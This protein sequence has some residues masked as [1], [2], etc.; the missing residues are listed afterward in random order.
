MLPVIKAKCFQTR[1]DEG[2]YLVLG[3][4][5][6]SLNL[7]IKREIH[8]KILSLQWF[9]FYINQQLLHNA[10]QA[11]QALNAKSQFPNL[12]RLLFQC[13]PHFEGRKLQRLQLH[14][15]I[16]AKNA[17]KR[18][19]PAMQGSRK[20]SVAV[21]LL[22][23]NTGQDRGKVWWKLVDTFSSSPPPMKV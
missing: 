8:S 23:L 6:N 2:F 17:S 16:M 20:I 9:C 13:L 5:S 21:Q 3:V 22:C 7:H 14:R 4:L 10:M 12:L 15:L 18:C 11:D 1:T 19:F